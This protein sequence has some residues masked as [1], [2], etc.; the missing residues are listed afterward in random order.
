MFDRR[1]CYGFGPRV[2]HSFSGP[3]PMRNFNTPVRNFNGP[4]PM[5]GMRR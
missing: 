3:V 4:V 5:H 2:L 1:T